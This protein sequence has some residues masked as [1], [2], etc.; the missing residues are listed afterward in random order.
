MEFTIQRDI[1]ARAI[2]LAGRAVKTKTSLPILACVLIEARGDGTVRIA[3]NDLEFGVEIIAPAT[4]QLPGKA[5]VSFERL[6]GFV[7]ALTADSIAATLDAAT[8]ALQL[9]GGKARGNVPTLD[10]D[11]FPA[12][13]AAHGDPLVEL[14]SSM[15]VTLLDATIPS[16]AKNDARVVLN[17]VHLEFA[18]DKLFAA[19]ADG[20]RMSVN[21]LDIDAP[22]AELAINLSSKVCTEI[23]RALASLDDTPVTIHTDERRNAAIIATPALTITGRIIEG[24]FPD[25]RQFVAELRKNDTAVVVCGRAALLAAVKV[26]ATAG[27]TDERIDVIMR[28]ADPTLDDSTDVL[29]LRARGDNGETIEDEVAATLDGEPIQFACNHRYMLD[30]LQ[31]IDAERVRFALRSH[32]FSFGVTPVGT[33][34]DGDTFHMIAPMHTADSE[35]AAAAD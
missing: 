1:F 2:G 23:T 22:P 11:L 26:A 28:R 4:V 16:A 30:A 12:M 34:R 21:A 35:V 13:A 18:A 8:N 29:V 19:A 32:R 17:S 31:G 6:R 15:L 24:Q 27:D 7:G 10:G 3:A 9:R 33:A 14:P 25:F 20:F 5:A